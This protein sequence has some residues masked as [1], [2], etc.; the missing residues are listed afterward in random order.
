MEVQVLN[1]FIFAFLKFIAKVAANGI[2]E[3]LNYKST[4]DISHTTDSCLKFHPFNG[5]IHFENVSFSYP[6]RPD[7]MI[8]KDFTLTV[9]AGKTI[10]V[11]GS[12]GCGKSTLI[13]LIQR[14]YDP[15]KGELRIDGHN[16]KHLD[17]EYV[18]SQMATVSQESVLFPMS[19]RDNIRLGRLDATDEDI[20][21]AAKQACVHDFIVSLKDR[22]N[23]CVGE[24][25]SQLSGGQKQKICIARAL[26]R[27]PKILLL[28]EPTSALDLQSET[29]IRDS[30]DLA[31]L[32]RT[33]LMIAHRLSTI[34]TAD[35]LVGMQNG[36]IV[37]I[38][39]H[40]ELMA[41]MG[42]YYEL[43]MQ[44][45]RN[46]DHADHGVAV[47]STT[48]HQGI[49]DCVDID[50]DE[51]MV[52]VNLVTQYNKSDNWTDY[53]KEFYSLER[54][55]WKFHRA[56]VPLIIIG[57]VLQAISGATL[58]VASIVTMELLKIFT[59]IDPVLQREQSYTYSGINC[60][61]AVVCIISN[62][63]CNYC[64]SLAGAKLTRNVRIKMFE[65]ALRQEIAF[66]DQNN[67][68]A[69]TTRLATT[70]QFCQGLT[71]E[72]LNIF[73]RALSGLGESI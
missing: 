48:S 58:V 44:D 71:T 59:I 49:S 3:I 62:T 72:S 55:I 43:N 20:E 54:F 41:K 14:F 29:D 66:H 17:T 42:L 46:A 11:Y 51:E 27:N 65:S 18:R 25:G 10:A 35:M 64:F 63:I 37:E 30:L 9:P 23:T 53:L 61:I 2:F 4:I 8:L 56:D 16:V 6:Q 19:I 31:K 26:I 5:D 36:T 40:G 34:R 13:Q 39:T 15:L 28:D 7:H 50:N 52:N 47:E 22:Y 69:L 57:F 12:S 45:R 68:S 73:T 24:R 33:T 60:S 32:G 70:S 21:M 67:S 38:G 1:S